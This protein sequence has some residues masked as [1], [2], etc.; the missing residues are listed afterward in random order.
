MARRPDNVISRA[1]WLDGWTAQELKAVMD[2]A[3]SLL[4]ALKLVM[5]VAERHAQW[6][7][8]IVKASIVLLEKGEVKQDIKTSSSTLKDLEDYFAAY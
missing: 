4:T 6:P 3:P 8:S 5:E 1:R 2:W 7:T